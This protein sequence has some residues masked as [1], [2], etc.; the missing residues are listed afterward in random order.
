MEV[1]VR[2]VMEGITGGV[3]YGVIVLALLEVITGAARAFSAGTFAWSYLDVW[4]KK[5]LMGRV[6]PILLL[7]LSG[8]AA[9]DLSLLGLEVNILTTAGIAAAATFAASVV[10]SILVN[11]NPSEP[12][13]PPEPEG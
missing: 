10:A 1:L 7:L 12:V 2:E 6:V 13:S 3:M 11:V 5:T 4:V 8:A 9:P